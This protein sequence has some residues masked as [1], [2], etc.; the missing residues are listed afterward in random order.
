MITTDEKKEIIIEILKE[1][2]TEDIVL[3]K[4]RNLTSIA[5]YFLLCSVDNSTQLNMTVHQI[6]KELKK[7][8]SLFCIPLKKHHLLGQ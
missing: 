3:L 1:M 4:V 5:D 6:E 7:W 2:K 8:E